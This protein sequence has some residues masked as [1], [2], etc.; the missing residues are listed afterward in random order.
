MA[1]I[2]IRES[3]HGFSAYETDMLIV[4]EE[5][6]LIASADDRAALVSYLAEAFGYK[7]DEA[8]S[9]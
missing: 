2:T 3:Q 9:I 1:D 6:A 8:E 4:N 5:A 7:D